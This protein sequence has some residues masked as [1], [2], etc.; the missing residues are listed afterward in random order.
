MLELFYEQT[1]AA[2]AAVS[3][4]HPRTLLQQID[5]SHRLIAIRGARGVG[6]TTLMLQHLRQTYSLSG[7]AIYATLDD[8]YFTKNRLIDLARV[9]LARGGKVLYLDEVHK[10]PQ[11]HWA[12]EIKNVYDLL[13]GLKVVFSGSS[14]LK[15][16]Q[17]QADLSRRALI[18]DV[19][20]LS[21]R[22]YI[23]LTTSAK[24][25]IFSFED[26]IQ[27][28]TELAAHIL[29]EHKVMPFQHFQPYLE[30]GY[31]PFFLENRRIYPQR[32]RELLKLVIE[33]D[34]NYLP[35]YTITD[36]VKISRLLYTLAS[37]APFKPNITKLSERVEL[38]RNRLTQYIYLLERAR[39][40]HLLHSRHTGLSALQKPDKI[41]LENTNMAFA[42]APGKM[43]MGNARETFFLNQLR[44]VHPNRPMPLLLTYP[45][46]GDF[47][48]DTFDEVYLFE[49]G[50]RNKGF[51]QIAH[52]P[53]ARIAADDLEI[54]AD[55]RIPL[56]LFGFLY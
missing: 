10:Y 43:D 33:V 6:K 4:E 12:Q 7:E 49:I 51:S 3:M 32:V 35:E 17:E 14:I 23:N 22:E 25:P 15:I 2:A 26:V 21:F 47:L 5:W 54:G 31:Y 41:Y 44:A 56:W 28:H 37:S 13:P 16:L 24:L 9:F 30:T 18:Y 50:G 52:H 40:L 11:A 39:M 55:H 48:V 45:E 1:Q 38:N 36:H 46:H 20:G 42:L 27:R 8:L 53:N 19:Q 34:L 29:H